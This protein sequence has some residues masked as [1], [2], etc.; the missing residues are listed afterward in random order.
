MVFLKV[1][2]WG[3]SSMV[4][5]AGLAFSEGAVNVRVLEKKPDGTHLHLIVP[6]IVV[7]L[8]LKFVPD[9]HLREARDQVR[10]WQPLIQAA[11]EGLEETP[12]CVLVEVTGPDEHV[13]VAKSGNSVV[14]DVDDS[15]D[16]VH[17]SVP[18]PMVRHVID[19]LSRPGHANSTPVGNSTAD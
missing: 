19:E 17:A 7:P 13:K 12:D 1:V 3:A 15:D 4:F 18:L 8:S 11:A 6:A 16:T 2:A 5:A 9:E 14:V 10:P